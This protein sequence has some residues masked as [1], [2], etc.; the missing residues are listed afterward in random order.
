MTPEEL[1][2]F[3]RRV[4]AHAESKSASVADCD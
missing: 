3:C 2:E 4:L 1:V